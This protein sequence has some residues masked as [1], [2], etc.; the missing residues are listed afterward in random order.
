MNRERESEES[1]AADSAFVCGKVWPTKLTKLSVQ[2]QT[3]I[4]GLYAITPDVANTADLVAMTQQALAGGARLVQYRNKSAA[5]TLRLEQARA[6]LQLCRTFSVPLIVND[7][8]DVAVEIG[9]DGVHLGREDMTITGIAEVRRRLGVGKIIGVSCYNR[10]ESAIEAEQQGADYVAFGTFFISATKPGAMVASTDLL[11]EARK[12]LR[13]PVVAIG[14]ITPDN[15]AKLIAQGADA[16]A[17]INALFSAPDIQ[18]MAEK[19]S[20]LFSL[21]NIQVTK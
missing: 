10:L 11:R 6:L 19:F 12:K 9:A 20:R 13:I 8:V 17:V 21:Q 15:A 3:G 5:D 4:S 1:H 2:W 14:G 7:H 16:V 18:S